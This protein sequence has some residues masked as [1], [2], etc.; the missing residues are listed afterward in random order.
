MNIEY[1]K[2]IDVLKALIIVRYYKN[3]K[4]DLRK[5]INDF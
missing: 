5:R 1:R 4:I 3:Y 2:K